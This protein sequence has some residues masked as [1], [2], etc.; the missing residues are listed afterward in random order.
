MKENK[1]Q[2]VEDF[3][4]FVPKKRAIWNLSD[5]NYGYIIPEQIFFIY[6]KL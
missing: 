3:V 4:S 2:K 1:Y 5:E 6:S